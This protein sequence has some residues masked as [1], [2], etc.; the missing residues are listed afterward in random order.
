MSNN[1]LLSINAVQLRGIADAAA[2]LRGPDG[3]PLYLVAVPDGLGSVVPELRFGPEPPPNTLLELDT[4]EVAPE[5]EHPNAVIL[6]VDSDAID[7]V[8]KFD[9]VFWSESA[10]EKFVLPYYASKCLWDAA[11]ELD[12]LSRAWYGRVPKTDAGAGDGAP[13]A[14]V[15][16][17]ALAHT[18]DSDWDTLPTGTQTGVREEFH[19]LYRDGENLRSMPVGAFVSEHR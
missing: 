10:V 4:Y 17:V 2:S 3:M 11:E 5:R 13:T 18:P 19:V 14:E 7:L 12:V 6:D 15:V 16:P 9:A 1:G 8:P